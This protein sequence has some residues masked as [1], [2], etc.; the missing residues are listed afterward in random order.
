MAEKLLG[1]ITGA[2]RAIGLTFGQPEP[3]YIRVPRRSGGAHPGGT[4]NDATRNVSIG[5]EENGAA[6]AEAGAKE[7][8]Q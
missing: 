7:T 2:G 3:S 5:D 1:F 4:G 6:R 8:R